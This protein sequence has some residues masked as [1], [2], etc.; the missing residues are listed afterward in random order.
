M[1]LLD[2]GSVAAGLGFDEELDRWAAGLGTIDP[3]PGALQLPA[4]PVAA[5]QLARLGVAEEDAVEPLESLSSLQSEPELRWLLERCRHR[6]LARLGRDAPAG[7]RWPQ[8]PAELGAA[9]RSFYVHL[10]LAVMPETL[11]WHRRH[12][13]P[14]AVSW[15]TLADLGRHMAIHRRMYGRTGVDEPW[16]MM[17]HLRGELLE[18]GRLQF[19]RHRI[20]PSHEI[21]FPDE[22]AQALGPG[23]RIGDPAL[24]IHIPET[25]PLTSQ[26]CEASL[27]QAR[28][29]FD[30][31]FPDANRRIATCTSWLLDD[32]LAAYLA[33]GSNILGFQRLFELV[34]G[35]EDDDE[36]ILTFVFR[37]P[38]A[39]LGDLP[40]DTALERAV[41]E[42]L[43]AGRH[44]R[45]RTGW[46]RL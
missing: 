14:E 21:W 39:A 5:A 13:L 27:R 44:W 43:A 25:G 8:L 19:D 26:S 22:E 33:P 15:A 32:Q 12:D 11:A 4:R 34:D 36:E 9:G 20:G 7:E 29:L 17:L 45:L 40:Q 42:H 10:Y 38:G 3:V 1:S 37:R 16:W 24:G 23:F 2:A 30:R 46:L 41:V 35:H 31:C 28:S 6:V 18:C